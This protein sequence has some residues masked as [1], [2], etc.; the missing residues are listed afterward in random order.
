MRED[1]TTVERLNEVGVLVRREIEARILGPVIEALA[2]EFPRDRII[3]IVRGVIIEIAREQGRALGASG[4]RTVTAF[5][6]TL[7]PWE[8]D[9]A[10]R[11]EIVEHTDDRL[12]FDVTRCRYAEMYRAL[13]IPEL[14]EVLSC[15]RDAALIEGFNPRITLTRTQTIMRGAPCCDFRYRQTAPV[16]SPTSGPA[17]GAAAERHTID[18]DSKE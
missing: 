12:A 9:D 5:R 11:L 2:R 8:R 7:G 15:N 1:H 4:D 6:S 10:M 14:G 13:G 16:D 3:D 17:D 18:E